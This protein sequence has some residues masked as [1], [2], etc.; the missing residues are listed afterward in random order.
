MKLIVNAQS[1][2]DE[3][4]AEW[5]ASIGYDGE[6]WFIY[7]RHWW[8]HFKTLG[9]LFTV[10]A[11]EKYWVERLASVK[12]VTVTK[13]VGALKDLLTWC[14]E[15]GLSSAAMEV[16][17]LP[18]AN[19]KAN[20]G[21][22]YHKRRRGKATEVTGEQARA[23]IARL[24]EWSKGVPP[25]RFP[26]RPRFVVALETGLRPK[27]L[28]QL[29]VPE[30]YQA[31]AAFLLVTADI[32]KNE[33]ERRVPL[34][35][36]ARAALDSVCPNEGLIF[37]RHD[38]R[39]SLE[40]AAQEVLPEHLA[41]TFCAYDFKHRAA[42]EMASTGDL[43]G[44]AY[45]MGWKQVTT[46]NKYAHPEQQ[47]AT[48]VLEARTAAMAHAAAAS[49]S[50]AAL[51][52]PAPAHHHRAPAAAAGVDQAPVGVLGW[53]TRPRSPRQHRP[54]HAPTPGNPCSAKERT[55]TSTGVTPLAP[56]DVAGEFPESFQRLPE[57]PD[58]PGGP[59]R[60]PVGV[61]P[62]ARSSPAD[63]LSVAIHILSANALGEPISHDQ[64]QALARAALLAT[65]VGRLALE[66]LD[67][68]PRATAAA[69][70]LAALM[71]VAAAADARKRREEN[72]GG[73]K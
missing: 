27:T 57:P 50:G 4:G 5:L 11:I 58:A 25:H 71:S 31:G 55:R 3:V 36:A 47:A 15:Q 12:R 70:Q 29:S 51:P 46:A 22:P 67:E 23:L 63:V 68:G 66:V 61:L 60:P 37:G 35:D 8:R 6:P 72:G 54:S 21:T 59:P 49:G 30:H 24:P 52:P 42:T 45:L 1:P 28:S 73:D 34:T 17:P 40:K 20:Q 38:Y 19:R 56:Q 10:G 32:D 18:T 53:G 7:L 33:F 69:V 64:A 62:Q 41:A 26:I 44:T 16:P 39:D 14:T 48:R 65:D 9:G 13:E 43:P 2:L